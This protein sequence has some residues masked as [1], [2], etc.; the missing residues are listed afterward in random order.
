[1]LLSVSVCVCVDVCLYARD[2]C[3]NPAR[4]NLKFHTLTHKHIE[5]VMVGFD[6]FH[7]PPSP[8]PLK[9]DQKRPKKFE[10]KRS[11]WPGIC[12][13]HIL[14]HIIFIIIYNICIYYVIM[15]QSALSVSLPR[16]VVGKG[17]GCAT[18]SEVTGSIR[19]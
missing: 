8:I 5:L 6:I 2:A 17:A 12:S 9:F 4:V 1:M 3:H 10:A 16:G 13:C 15:S 7:P 14:L 19:T 18:N 11:W